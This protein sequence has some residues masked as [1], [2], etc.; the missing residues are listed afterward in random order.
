[1]KFANWQNKSMDRNQD[2]NSLLWADRGQLAKW[3][4]VGTSSVVEKST[5]SFGWWIVL[6]FTMVKYYKIEHLNY[7][8]FIG[9]KL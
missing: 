3:W 8:H 9:Y 1:M 5:S 4:P 7:M 2:N 6:M